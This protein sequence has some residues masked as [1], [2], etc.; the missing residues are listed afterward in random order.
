MRLTEPI[1]VL[2]QPLFAR[3]YIAQ[4]ISLLGDS[5]TWVGVALLAYEFG[6]DQSS[7]ILATSLT[8]RVTSFVLFGSYAGILADRFN[9][10]MIMIITNTFRMF[11]II[12][13]AFVNGTTGLYILIFS[14]N[15]FNAFFSPAYK[16][17]IP[18]LVEGRENYGNAIAL[19]NA[20]WQLLGILGPG[21]AGILAVTWGARQIFFVDALSFIISSVLIFFIPIKNISDS[22]PLSQSISSIWENMKTGTRLVFKTKPIRFSLFIELTGALAGAQILVNTIGQIRV[23]MLLGD[24]EY[25]F[26]MS[27]FG[28]GATIAAFTSSTIDKSANK[29]IMLSLGALIL[30]LA[31]TFANSASFGLM[32]FLWII[33]GIGISYT[34]MPSQILI[35]ENINQEDQGKAYGSHFAWS[36]VWWAAG[37]ILAGISGTFF[38]DYDFFA[39]GITALTLLGI[40]ILLKISKRKE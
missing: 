17:C 11:I 23:D 14:L 31:V 6:G 38:R 20:T 37:Y 35:A 10:K 3:L 24:D 32:T 36:H 34:D 4:A 40:L 15:V 16:A 33:A 5:I 28:I 9:R 25:G 19:S 21:L 22:K 8:L 13:L 39:G 18:Q 26:I 27:A 12:S 7:R 2:R 29:T 1:K 30:G